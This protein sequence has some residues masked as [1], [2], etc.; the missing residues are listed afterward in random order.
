MKRFIAVMLAAVFLAALPAGAIGRTGTSPAVIKDSEVYTLEPSVSDGVTVSETE[1]GSMTVTAHEEDGLLVF[2]ETK[3]LAFTVEYG[4]G[5]LVCDRYSHFFDGDARAVKTTGEDGTVLYSFSAEEG[6]SVAMDAWRSV[7]VNAS[8]SELPKLHIDVD[9]PFEDVDRE[10]WVDASFSITLGTK[11]YSSGDYEGTGSV[12]GR[13]NSSWTRPKKPYSIKLSSKASLLDI[14]KTKKY[15]IIP[16]Y[17]DGSLMRNYITYKVYQG[18]VGIDYVPKCEFVDVYLNGVYNGIYILVE[19]IDIE[20]NKI[21]I[22]EADAENLSGGYLIEK[23]INSKFDF[24]E[25]LWFNCPYWAN[26][27]QDYFVMKAPEP[28]DEALTAQMLEYL[29]NYM[30]DVH[31]A[32]MGLSDESWERYVDVSSWIDFIILQEIAKNIDGNFKTS[33]FLTK[34]RDDDKIYMTAPWDFDLA[35]GRV[36]WNNQSEAHNDVVDCPPADTYDGFMVVNSS[37]PWMDKLYDTVPEFRAA[38]MERY[39]LY[40]GT[41]IEQMF[42]MIDEQ[43]AYLTVVQEPNYELWH[44]GFHSGVYSLRTWLAGRI[45]WLDGEWIVPETVYPAGDVNM[46]GALTVEDALLALRGAMSLT[47]LGDAAYLA[48][49]NGDG[50]VTITDALDILRT[51]MGIIAQPGPSPE[52]TQEPELTQEPEPPEA[53]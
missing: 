40:R 24:D 15:A 22:D 17:D 18:L 29:E 38:L 16:G 53:P 34:L 12:K 8:A 30:Q 9:M 46:D 35:Y 45:E 21:D 42:D 49:F 44:K 14:P 43:A 28:D 13:G 23:D 11:E 5:W 3:E 1:E 36:N 51:A 48:D 6:G 41:L 47:A 27:A 33:C 32:I 31:N 7:C 2:D 25:D 50:E 39:E 37:N 19:R 20:S 26:Q 4:E 52:P 10:N